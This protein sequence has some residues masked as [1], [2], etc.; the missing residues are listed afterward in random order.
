MDIEESLGALSR[1]ARQEEPPA[2]DVR[3]R[4]LRTLADAPQVTRLDL[5]PVAVAT[6]AVTVAIIV[7][8]VC[9]PSWRA[10]SDPWIAVV[11]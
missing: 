4:V 8:L 10:V 6:M 9:L 2:I 3:D 11:Q 7:V 1:A 5:L